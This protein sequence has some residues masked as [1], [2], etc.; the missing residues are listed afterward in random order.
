MRGQFPCSCGAYRQTDMG[1]AVHHAP[2]DCPR[3]RRAASPTNCARHCLVVWSA[4]YARQEASLPLRGVQPAQQNFSALHTMRGKYTRNCGAH[5]Q[6]LRTALV[7]SEH[8]TS[9]AAN[10]L[11]PAARTVYLLST[12]LHTMGR[13]FP[14]T[15]GAELGQQIALS[16][17]CHHCQNHTR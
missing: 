9:C 16:S 1:T 5:L 3:L 14:R 6:R 12:L 4:N 2:Q 11:A 8:L 7:V 10:F 13:N 17:C 15:C